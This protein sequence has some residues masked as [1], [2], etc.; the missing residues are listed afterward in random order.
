MI[1]AAHDGM[2]AAFCATAERLSGDIRAGRR[3]GTGKGAVYSKVV[4]KGQEGA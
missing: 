2:A 4:L 3:K 1:T